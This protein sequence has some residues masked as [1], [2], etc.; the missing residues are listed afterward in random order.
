MLHLLLLCAVAC[1]MYS[2]QTFTFLGHDCGLAE[3]LKLIQ[4]L[5]LFDDL[6][7]PQAID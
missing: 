1:V 4:V 3:F 7:T 5:P 6:Q 2:I